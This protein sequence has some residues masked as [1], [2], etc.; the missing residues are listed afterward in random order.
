MDDA[1]PLAPDTPAAARGHE[2]RDVAFRPILWGGVGLLLATTL[3]FLMVFWL[4]G[5][6]ERGAAERSPAVNPLTTAYGRRLPPEPRLQTHPIRDLKQLRAAEDEQLNTYGW[7]DRNTGTVRIPIA[8]A[9]EVLAQ[10]GLPARPEAER[11]AA[12]RPETAPPGR[13]E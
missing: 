10:R 12:E 9:M 2:E 7:I 8:R 1:H 13:G 11:P 3:I 4:F 6:L 5:Y